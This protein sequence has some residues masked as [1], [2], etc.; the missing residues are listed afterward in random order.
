[1]HKDA[2]KI[3]AIFEPGEQSNGTTQHYLPKSVMARTKIGAHRTT[4]WDEGA[5]LGDCTLSMMLGTLRFALSIV[6]FV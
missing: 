4:G 1:V 3:N 2:K 6:L 5:V